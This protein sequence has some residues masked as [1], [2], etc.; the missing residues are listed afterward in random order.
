VFALKSISPTVV[1]LP[2]YFSADEKQR[3]SNADLRC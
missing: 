2:I 1:F 3:L